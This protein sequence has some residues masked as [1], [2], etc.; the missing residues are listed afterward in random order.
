MFKMA[1]MEL[2]MINIYLFYMQFFFFF[3]SAKCDVKVLH[4]QK[5]GKG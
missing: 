2:Q 5:I 3:Y 1:Y 4:I